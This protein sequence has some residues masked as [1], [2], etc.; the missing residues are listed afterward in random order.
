M[1]LK[2]KT[3]SLYSEYGFVRY[4]IFFLSKLK[5]Q[6]CG[7]I[8]TH[9]LSIGHVADNRQLDRT[10]KEE[11]VWAGDLILTRST[12][13][14]EA[15]QMWNLN[16]VSLFLI[17]VDDVVSIGW[18]SHTRTIK[19]ERSNRDIIIGNDFT[20][21]TKKNIN[22]NWHSRSLKK[23][24][25]KFT[26]CHCHYLRRLVAFSVVVDDTHNKILCK[27]IN[28]LKKSRFDHRREPSTSSRWKEQQ[29]RVVKMLLML[30]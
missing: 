13:R 27:E 12:K 19:K 8:K 14:S 30:F 21:N 26:P 18:V 4:H 20:C 9:T 25:I 1:L 3:Y 22:A 2:S 24:L 6:L 23:R 10:R 16:A 7:D 15:H 5:Q 11:T 29:K 17:S 28:E